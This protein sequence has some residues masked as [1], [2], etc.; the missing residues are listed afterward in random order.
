MK[1]KD[2]PHLG[3]GLL[4]AGLIRTGFVKS[5]SLPVEATG[6]NYHGASFVLPQS[7]PFNV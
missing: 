1:R 7:G 5:Q 4:G 3:T 6:M 2:D